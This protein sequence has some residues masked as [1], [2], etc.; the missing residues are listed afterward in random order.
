MQKALYLIIFL[1][2]LPGLAQSIVFK[3]GEIIESVAIPDSNDTYALYLPINYNS[4]AP[5]L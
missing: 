3:K 2:F 4:D 5:S 1:F